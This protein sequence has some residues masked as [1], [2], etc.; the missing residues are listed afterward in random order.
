M[1]SSRSTFQSYL[2]H[3]FFVRKLPVVT[4]I[5]I[6]ATVLLVAAAAITV[7]AVYFSVAGQ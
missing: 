3:F 5:G 6:A 7:P 1:F 4:K 2:K